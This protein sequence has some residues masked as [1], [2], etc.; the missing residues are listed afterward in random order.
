MLDCIFCKIVA[1]QEKSYTFW[2]DDKHIAFLSIFPN[3]QGTSVVIP[4]QHYP[5][6]AFDLPDQV[7]TELIIATKNVAKH[8]DECFQDVGRTAMVLEGF[9]VNHV[10]A[11]LYPMHG[12]A[13]MGEWKPIKS[14]VDKY[15]HT[16][17]GYISSHDFQNIT[18]KELDDTFQ[19]LHRNPI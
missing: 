4:K 5:S 12:T 14:N 11:K 9:G 18:P 19:K 3:T 17:E 10:H 7:L 8:L 2:E 16:Y 6:Y 15:F 1:R 13:E